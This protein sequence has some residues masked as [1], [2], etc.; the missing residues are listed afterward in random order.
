MFNTFVIVGNM[1]TGELKL[2]TI[3]FDV[4]VIVRVTI[5]GAGAGPGLEGFICF[6][7]TFFIFLFGVYFNVD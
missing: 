3:P 1:R 2:A 5:D 4:G 6:P 7:F